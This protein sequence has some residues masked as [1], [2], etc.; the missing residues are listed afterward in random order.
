MRFWPLHLCH[1][2]TLSSRLLVIYLVWLDY[3]DDDRRLHWQ[4]LPHGHIHSTFWKLSLSCL[5]EVLLE[6][7]YYGAFLSQGWSFGNTG[8]D[9]NLYLLWL[10]GMITIVAPEPRSR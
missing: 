7:I 5:A 4:G 1:V 8:Q 6:G 2:S 9:L 10:L 3:Y